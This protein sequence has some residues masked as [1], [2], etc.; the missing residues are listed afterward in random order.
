MAEDKKTE[1]K[2]T[3]AG[4]LAVILIR[5]IVSIKPDVRKTLDLLKLR[6]KNVCVLIEDNESNRGMLQTVKDYVTFGTID[7]ETEKILVEKRGEKTKD[8]KLKGFFRLHPPRKGYGRKGIKTPFKVGGALGNR[9]S[10]I[11]DLIV[12][13]I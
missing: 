4:K 1:S 3:Q 13:M 5:S 8:G 12:R 10:A 6:N 7:A 11:N 9:D 2:K